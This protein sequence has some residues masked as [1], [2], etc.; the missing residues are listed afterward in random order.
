MT[1]PQKYNVEGFVA[2]L[3]DGKWGVTR[4]RIYIEPAW[5]PE[6]WPKSEPRP[7][8]I[9]HNR[10]PWKAIKDGSDPGPTYAQWLAGYID[11]LKALDNQP[12]KG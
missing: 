12:S 11:R 6:P 9:T 2:V 7:D 8:I 4:H 3:Q 1:E 10:V 5:K